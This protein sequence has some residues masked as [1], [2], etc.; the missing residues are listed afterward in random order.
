MW[1][2]GYLLGTARDIQNAAGG[3]KV[4]GRLTHTSVLCGSCRNTSRVSY[5]AASGLTSE[6]SLWESNCCL[7][8]RRA[9]GTA[10]P[11]PGEGEGGVCNFWE[12][13]GLLFP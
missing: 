3:Q 4:E 1:T 9:G 8:G 2:G 6:R 7:P 12:V 10:G 5:L 11:S 13:H